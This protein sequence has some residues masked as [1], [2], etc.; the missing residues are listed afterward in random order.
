MSTG[1]ARD[2]VGGNA[3]SSF[4]IVAGEM[5]ASVAAKIGEPVDGEHADAAAIGQDREPL[6]R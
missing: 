5:P 6:A 4:S 2:Q 1:L 3:A